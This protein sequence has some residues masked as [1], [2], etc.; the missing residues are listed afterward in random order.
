MKIDERILESIETPGRNTLIT[1]PGGSGK[2][3]IIKYLNSIRNDILVAA[4]S[5][6]ASQNIGGRTVQS[7]FGITPRQYTGEESWN[8]NRIG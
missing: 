7:V 6:I 8:K 2:S 3:Q 1:G 5:G 4:P